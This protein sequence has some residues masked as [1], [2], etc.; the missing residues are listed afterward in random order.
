MRTA[1]LSQQSKPKLSFRTGLVL[2][3]LFHSM[4]S[5][6]QLPQFT[7][8]ITKTEETCLG[9]GTLSLSTQDTDPAATITYTVYALPD[10][11]T[12]IAVLNTNFLGGLIHGDYRIIA[13]QSLG[14]E[15]NSQTQD[16]TISNNLIPLAYTISSTNSSCGSNGTMTATV[17]SGTGVQYEI[18]SGPV[19]RP[20]Q[21]SPF[22]NMLPAGVYQVRVFDNCG[23][24]WVATHTLLSETGSISVEQ[25]PTEQTELVTCNSITVTSHITSAVNSLLVYPITIVYTVFPPAGGTPTVT[26]TTMASGNVSDLETTVVIPYYS[27]QAYIY[28]LTITDACGKIYNSG[29]ISINKPFLGTVQTETAGCGEYSLKYTLSNYKSPLT[30]NFTT[31][32][33]GFDPAVF[34]T[35]HP[36]P[37]SITDGVIKYGD[38]THPVPFGHYTAQITDACGKTVTVDITLEEI[39]PQPNITLLPNQGCDSGRSKVTILVS[40]FRFVSGL[41]TLAPSAF[42]TALPLNV[43]SFINAQGQWEME[44]VPA[45]DYEIT[46]VDECGNVYQ[47][48]FTVSGTVTEIT[49]TTWTGCE[50]GNGS[51]RIRGVFT[52]LVGAE[53]IAAPADYPQILPYDVTFNINIFGTFSMNGFPAGDYTF[54]VT[55]NCGITHTKTIT[56]IGYTVTADS[57]TIT[58]HCGS[59]DLHFSHTSN[60]VSERFYLQKLNPV[61][62]LWGHPQTNVP[63][64]A[65]SEPNTTNSYMILNNTTNYNISYLGDFRIIKSYQTFENGSI[66]EFK[67]CVE[68]TREFTFIN[69]I[70]ITDIRKSSCSGLSSDVILTATGVPPLTYQITTK[71][72][73]PF[74]IDNGNNPVFA[75]LDPAIYNFLVFDTCGNIVNRLAD[76]ALLPSLVNA[77][78]PGNL[79]ACDDSDNDSKALFDLTSQNTT[80][81][82]SQSAADYM[83]S[84][85]ISATDAT[86]NVNP[87]PANYNSANQTIYCRLQYRTQTNCYDIVSFNLIVN[88]SLQLQMEKHAVICAGNEVTLVADAGF[89]SYLWS[90]AQTTR[91]ITVDEPGNYTVEVTRTTNGVTCSVTVAIEVVLSA[92][93]II[94]QLITTDWTNDDNVIS[95]VL[96]QSSL[97]NYS[98]SLDNI[99][100]Q[101]GNTFY[102]L[103]AGE[104]MV[105]VKDENGCEPTNQNVFLLTYPKFFTPNGDGYHDYWQILFAALEPNM[106][107]Y[108]FDRYGKLLKQVDPKGPGWDGFY[109]GSE[110]PSTDYWFHVI[111]ENGKEFRGHF[112]MKR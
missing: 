22:F 15:T 110:L 74:F 49:A 44:N 88:P 100:F 34:N 37:F 78:Q 84:Y 7:L 72:G 108:I 23:E 111:R 60:G 27:N 2:L 89:D 14:A 42:S 107:I 10:T 51:V 76:V 18:I 52:N 104:Y 9:N 33:A 48:E 106:K 71:N 26:T 77:Q 59:F 30:V 4:L 29:N 46:F 3:L 39:D 36:G 85:H 1:F 90:T 24:G 80:V 62:G 73:F 35:N 79:I 40:G 31:A 102:G 55:D 91:M 68:I 11:A 69:A 17:F 5:L 65:G 67:T 20:V 109:N 96:D 95:I 83:V 58:E 94:K 87:L 101:S 47:T 8:T 19:I 105:Y 103:D 112:T 21:S 32:P 61:T 41:V 45:G 93:A 81:L 66:G 43:S 50:N 57:Y 25:V 63:Y 92:P 98:Y 97:G 75:N 99:H 86:N 16:I 53:I 13:T 64:N 82:G 6:A 56:V 38:F 70:Q 54:K 12:A 28:T